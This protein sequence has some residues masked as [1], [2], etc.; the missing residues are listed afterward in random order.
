MERNMG[1]KYNPFRPDKIVPPFMFC[2]RMEELRFLDHCLLQTKNGNP[3]HFLIEGERGIGKSSL[4]LSELFVATGKVR[5]LDG[6]KTLDFIVVEVSLEPEDTYF[7]VIKRIIHQLKSAIGERDKLKAYALATLAFISRVEAGGVRIRDGKSPEDTELFAN[8]QADLVN[9]IGRIEG[10]ADGILFL[11]DEA[12]KAP[13]SANLGQLCKLLTEALSKK[14]CDHLCI[15]LAGLP[16]LIGTLRQSHESSPRMFKTMGLKPL[17][18]AEREQVLDIGMQDASEKNGFEIKITAE[19][20]KLISEFSEGYPHFLQEFAYCA[21]EADTDNVIDRQ[22]VTASLISENGAF[23]QLGRKYFEQYYAAPD[24]DDYRTMLDC[25]AKHSDAWV[26]RTEIIKETKLK[27]GTVDNGLRALKKTNIILAN[28]LK[29]GQ[30]R[31]PTKSFA[32]WINAKKQAEAAKIG[33]EPSLL[34]G[35]TKKT[36]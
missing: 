34:E 32:A 8:L 10:V 6:D 18:S 16:G 36:K 33:E 31:L 7:S 4:L 3:Q 28:D 9:I 1:G 29:S 14:R 30:Y 17:E 24:S 25:M 26:T 2:G 13:A 15:G 20:K 11:I 27:S 21:F 23:D 12:D 19:A 22:D 35:T 5:T